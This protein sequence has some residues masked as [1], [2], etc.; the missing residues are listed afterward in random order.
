MPH[1]DPHFINDWV[2]R[3]RKQSLLCQC[4]C[5]EC[6]EEEAVFACI[7]PDC[8]CNESGDASA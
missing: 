4:E 3:R 8:W 2:G 5:A 1:D 7:C 6:V